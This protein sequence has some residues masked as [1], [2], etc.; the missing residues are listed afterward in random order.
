MDLKRCVEIHSIYRRWEIQRVSSLWKQEQR[1]LAPE[2]LEKGKRAALN[3]NNGNE[4]TQGP[5]GAPQLLEAQLCKPRNLSQTLLISN[6]SKT[7]SSFQ[8]KLLPYTH[9]G[10]Y[11]GCCHLKRRSLPRPLWSPALQRRS[12]LTEQTC[13]AARAEQCSGWQIVT[14]LLSRYHGEETESDSYL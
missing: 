11:Q 6:C 4:G 14:P 10:N 12:L 3:S 1:E 13:H 5:T 7:G 9:S 8:I 2:H